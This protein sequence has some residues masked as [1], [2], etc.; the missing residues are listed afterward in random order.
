MGPFIMGVLA[1]LNI[2]IDILGN[3]GP[4][5][6]HIAP[7]EYQFCLFN[8]KKKRVISPTTITIHELD[9]HNNT[10]RVL[11]NTYLIV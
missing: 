5:T 6:C 11:T 10:P 4:I 3:M 8:Q 9:T 2:F 1:I 7:T